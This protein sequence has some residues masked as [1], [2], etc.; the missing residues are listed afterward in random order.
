MVGLQ[1]L[2]ALASLIVNV[3]I[4]K[5]SK[6]F[7]VNEAHAEMMTVVRRVE[8][9]PDSLPLPCAGPW[10]RTRGIAPCLYPSGRGLAVSG[11]EG[12]RMG[13][14]RLRHGPLPSW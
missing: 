11:R 13:M 10:D 7:Y 12:R 2:Q 14:G 6:T 5:M 1:V 4:Y 8:H 3:D 9:T